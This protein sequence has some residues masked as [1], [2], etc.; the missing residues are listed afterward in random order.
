MQVVA[1]VLDRQLLQRGVDPVEQRMGEVL[2][3][4]VS[5][6]DADAV[7]G[8]HRALAVGYPEHA[9]ELLLGSTVALFILVVGIDPLHRLVLPTDG[10]G[11]RGVAGGPLQGEDSRGIRPHVPG[12]VGRRPSR[13]AV[14][15]LGPIMCPHT[16]DLLAPPRRGN[17]RAGRLRA[18][19]LH[20]PRLP[21]GYPT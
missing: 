20:I 10:R 13:P 15:L 12:V 16:S 14:R 1:Q 11:H 3:V 5:R 4:P 9:T 18:R 6:P 8:A 19:C 7:P 2:A 17:A 21:V